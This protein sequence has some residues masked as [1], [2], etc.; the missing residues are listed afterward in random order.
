MEEGQHTEQLR[1]EAVD[2]WLSN[3]KQQ[4]IKPA[5]YDR[6][7]TSYKLM[8]KYPI[9]QLPL[10]SVRCMDIQKY[11]NQLANQGYAMSTIKKQFTLLTAFFKFAFSQGDIRSPVYIGAKVP[12]Q[13]AIK[14]PRREI[15]TY[16]PI[17]EK[18]LMRVLLTLSNRC[19][20]AAVLM[21][22]GG[23][24]VGEALSLMWED[25]LWGRKALVINKTLVRLSAQKGKTFVQGSAKSKTS[26]RTIPLSKTAMQ[27]LERLWETAANQQGYIF[28]RE[29]NPN[30]PISHD[31]IRYYLLQACD[32]AGVPYKGNHVFRHTFATNRYNKGCD[33]KI[34]SKLLGHAD[35][36]ITY[37]IY[38]HL[39][40]D[41]LEEMRKVID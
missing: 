37:N 26:N 15:E 40:G 32:K 27:V 8:K 41:A 17:E 6:L 13:E 31:M 12:N 16:S 34:L 28:A 7:L 33:V 20:G 21:L 2:E 30:M 23:L 18:T 25:V 39:Y 29:D 3:Y 1:A 10:S 5:S 4:S 9:A 24:R 11:V 35:V 38:I 14:K 36:A 19:Y 22:E